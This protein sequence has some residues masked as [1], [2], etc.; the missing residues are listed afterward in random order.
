MYYEQLQ[1]NHCCS[2]II[3]AEKITIVVQLAI[4]VCLVYL[5]VVFLP[6][7]FFLRYI[8]PR[9][10]K[11]FKKHCRSMSLTAW[12]V[13]WCYTLFCCLLVLSWGEWEYKHNS[14]GIS[15]ERKIPGILIPYIC[16]KTLRYWWSFYITEIALKWH[17][18]SKCSF[19]YK[20]S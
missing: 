5:D 2:L 1:K 9:C 12:V 7:D 14:R 11:I 6:T 10:L 13:Q 19:S 18:R 17:Q 8:F 4:L 3:F 20:V 16:R 15:E